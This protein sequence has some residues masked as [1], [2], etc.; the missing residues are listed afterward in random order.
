MVC[1]GSRHL[2]CLTIG[3]SGSNPSVNKNNL[4]RKLLFGQSRR[5][6]NFRQIKVSHSVQMNMVVAKS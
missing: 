2:T 4:L 1:F 5:N 3:L 6:I